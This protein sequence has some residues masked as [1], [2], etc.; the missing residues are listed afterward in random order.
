MQLGNPIIPPVDIRKFDK[1]GKRDLNHDGDFLDSG[2]NHQGVDL[3]PTSDNILAS[4]DGKITFVGKDQYGGLYI[5]VTNGN[6]K[7]RYLHNRQNLVKIG[8]IVKQGQLIGYIGSTGNSSGRHLH[9]EVWLDGKRINPESVITFNPNNNIMFDQAFNG[10]TTSTQKLNLPAHEIGRLQG[11]INT[12]D[13]KLVTEYY[14]LYTKELEFN[15]TNKV[16]TESQ[17]TID[18]LKKQLEEAK[19]VTDARVVESPTVNQNLTVQDSIVEIPVKGDSITLT[20]P[21]TPEAETLK[22]DLE[23]AYKAIQDLIKKN[24]KFDLNILVTG[25]VSFKNA[26]AN[27]GLV[28]ILPALYTFYE[29]QQA[30]LSAGVFMFGAGFG[31]LYPLINKYIAKK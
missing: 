4:H 13:P 8:Q 12:R 1:F 6:Y 3:R 29:S 27:V 14:S 18:D 17:A 20:L 24:E 19:K 23:T 7:T 31:I 25:I 11:L 9:F 15:V 22:S 21:T 28:G 16:K 30:N 10:L 5:D 26:I 2:E